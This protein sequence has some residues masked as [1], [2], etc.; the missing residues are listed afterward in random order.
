MIL[1]VIGERAHLLHL[2]SRI[3]AAGH[4]LVL[5]VVGIRVLSLIE[6]ALEHGA[7]VDVTYARHFVLC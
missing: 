2:A 4:S 3:V 5:I 7:G 6:H 1:N